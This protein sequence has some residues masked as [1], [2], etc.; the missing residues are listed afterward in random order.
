MMYLRKGGFLIIRLM[1]GEVKKERLDATFGTKF[2]MIAY[3]RSPTH[4]IFLARRVGSAFVN[5]SLIQGLFHYKKRRFWNSRPKQY[6]Y[7][8]GVP[9]VPNINNSVY[10]QT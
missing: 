3:K 9:K 2:S 7:I 6:T 8:Q 5:F 10:M 1:H 4:D